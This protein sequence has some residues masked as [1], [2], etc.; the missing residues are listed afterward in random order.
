MQV[1]AFE[2][3]IPLRA[4][5]LSINRR[6]IIFEELL[7]MDVVLDNSID[8]DEMLCCLCLHCLQVSS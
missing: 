5:Q 3:Y 2:R 7:K 1:R 8:P 6:G 4:N